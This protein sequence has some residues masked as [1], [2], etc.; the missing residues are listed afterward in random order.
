MAESVGKELHLIFVDEDG[1]L[2]LEKY[3]NVFNFSRTPSTDGK[4]QNY[5]VPNEMCRGD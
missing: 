4:T 2:L 3:K 5:L 1:D